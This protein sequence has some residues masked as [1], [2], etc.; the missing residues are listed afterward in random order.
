MSKIRLYKN[1]FPN[2]FFQNS[3]V[4]ILMRIVFFLGFFVSITFSTKLAGSR[5]L[6]T[7]AEISAQSFLGI[8]K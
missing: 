1:N 4:S 8:I 7:I 5:N 6:G 3:V 2:H